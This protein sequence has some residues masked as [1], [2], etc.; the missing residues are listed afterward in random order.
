MS[1]HEQ[2]GAASKKRR[3]SES[4]GK[5]R[6]ARSRCWTHTITSHSSS[7]AST[8]V[9]TTVSSQMLRCPLY[10]TSWPPKLG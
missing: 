4:R 8:K 5:P 6:W 1:V 3:A 7:W 9:S 2:A 10:L